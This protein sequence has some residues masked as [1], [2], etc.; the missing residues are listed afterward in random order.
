[1]GQ[2]MSS[3]KFFGAMHNTSILGITRV[4]TLLCFPSVTR[5]LVFFSF[6]FLSL[7]ISESCHSNHTA[8]VT[9]YRYITVTV[10]SKQDPFFSGEM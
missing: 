4:S 3:A 9:F 2:R 6:Y 8:K 1:M 5:T 7:I 10:L